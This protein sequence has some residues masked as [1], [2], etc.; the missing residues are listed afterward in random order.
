MLVP[1][2]YTPEFWALE[3]K[4]AL[5]EQQKDVAALAMETGIVEDRLTPFFE[6]PLLSTPTFDEAYA[7]SVALSV[8]LHAEHTQYW[9]L[10]THDQ[11]RELYSWLGSARSF[12]ERT[13]GGR[14]KL[15]LPL[16]PERKRLLELAGVPHEL[17]TEDV[18]LFDDAAL[19]LLHLY[20]TREKN[21]A[22][23]GGT[24]DG[25]LA[26]LAQKEKEILLVLN[27]VSSTK[28]RDKSGI[29][30]GSRMGRPEKA[31]QR[32]MTG[33]PH[34]LFPIG[35]QGGRMRSY[36][37]AL[38]A[39]FVHASYPVKFC[40]SCKQKTPLPRCETCD[41]P[42]V[43]LLH[44]DTCGDVE[45]CPHDPKP[46]ADY[47]ID[48]PRIFHESLKKLGYSIY[49]DLIK[50]VRGTSNKSH[51][52]EHP[53]K[54]IVRAKHDVYVNKDGTIRYDASELTLTHFKPREVEAPLEKLR[55]LGYT[56]DIDG[57]PLESDDQVLEL[58]PQAV[59]LPCC[60][61]SPDEPADA[62]LARAAGFVDELLK[63]LYGLPAYHC[64]SGPKDLIG[65]YII[66]LA[67]HTS[68]GI[69][70]RI[71]GFSKTQGFLAHPLFHAAMRRDCDGD[72]SCFLLLMD[73]FLN[74]SRKYLGESRGSTMDAPLV[75][76]IL[77]NPAEVDDMAFNVDIVGEYPLELYEAG[78]AFKKPNEIKVRRLG[79]VLGT[80]AQ[81][82]GMRFTHPT[83][84]INAGVLCSAYKT[85]PSMEEK[86]EGQM[87][88]A[89]K[90]RA[91]D[92]PD[93]ARLVIEKHF[94]RDTKGNLR[95]FSQQEYRCV[96][97]NEKYRRPPL[98]GSCK[99]CNGK[100]IFTITEGSVVKYLEPSIR[101]AK[102]YNLPAYLQ[103]DLELTKRRVEANFGR[104]ADRQE[105]LDKFFG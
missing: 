50:G 93:V 58:F 84:D 23:A 36:Q 51:L 105:G 25:V 68:A 81:F 12:D 2:G 1:P 32:Q 99:E 44:C 65:H 48:F 90:I 13:R 67:P 66:G 89:D 72:E 54:G 45:S 94:L 78:L 62:V 103:Q 73:T 3:V 60:S 38:E 33:T 46:W 37:A 24:D 6:T 59:V 31:K 47:R 17:A 22:A 39:G 95:K 14:F 34:T 86:L 35:E 20:G 7:I 57:R 43:Q 15:L 75:L 10:L 4:K 74:F 64:L 27:E 18:L 88:L 70:G 5:A 26:K 91:C 97:C 8:P 40:S 71:I 19:A 100:V 83:S 85:L 77:L 80:P 30:I 56:H 55:D 76:T 16:V 41:A 82:E 9:T 61:A 42:T 92:A 79:D 104:D 49:P 96:N 102:K 63:R 28:L 29:F 87:K 11:H 69:I 98:R 101:L 52:V 21:D 53:A